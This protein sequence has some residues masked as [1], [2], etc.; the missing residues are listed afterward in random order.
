MTSTKLAK[1]WIKHGMDV[2]E[3][4]HLLA[5]CSSVLRLLLKART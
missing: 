2:L 3:K 1:E 5:F 4:G